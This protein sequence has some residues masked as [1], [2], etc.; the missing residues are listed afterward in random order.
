MKR[1]A[2][3]ILIFLSSVYGQENKQYFN[4]EYDLTPFRYDSVSTRYEFYYSVSDTGF[5]RTY[6]EK[7]IFI[8]PRI[9]IAVVNTADSMLV[10]NQPYIIRYAIV[11][12][13]KP[14]IY[15]GKLD[16][17][18]DPGIYRMQVAI[19][20]YYDSAKVDFYHRTIEVPQKK[21]PFISGIEL[22]SRMITGSKNTKSNFYKNS[23]E[24]YPN[25]R[26]T[27]YQRMPVVFY[28]TEI[29]GLKSFD[30]ELNFT[31]KLYN[32]LN[33][34]VWSKTNSLKNNSNAV[35]EPGFINMKKLASGK[36]YLTAK[37]IDK[38]G[39]VL[40]EEN[41]D[42]YYVSG[43]VADS[44]YNI[45]D[46]LVKKNFLASPFA[47]LSGPEC[48][49]I[50]RSAECLASVEERSQYAKL[51]SANQKR[52]FLYSF[53]QKRDSDPATVENEYYTEFK[54]RVKYADERFKEYKKKGSLTDRGII[55][56][57]YGKPSK[58]E[59]KQNDYYNKP[60]QIWYYYN[61]EGGV[62]FVF[63]DPN[64][65]G[66]YQLLDSTK[67]GERH[68]PNWMDRLKVR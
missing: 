42:F 2:V 63:G 34:V 21:P 61:I 20:D 10:M 64:G 38:A 50:F 25:P 49:V 28:Y 33:K 68:D 37:L 14:Q 6:S 60:Y 48:D 56:V 16:F 23:M 26:S 58:I 19:G 55:Y 53:W 15:L 35:V 52:V 43:I 46:A 66:I 67:R 7:G 3:L 44:N 22:A 30:N 39:K 1:L 59:R 18:L 8:Y 40:D 29:Y 27:F 47:I 24:V 51:D 36:Y 4:F 12:T 13:T 11:D 54:E 57:K 32:S 31:A 41:K 45:S 5:T 17:K 9:D 62:Y 65:L